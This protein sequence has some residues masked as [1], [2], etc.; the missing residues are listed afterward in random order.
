MTDPNPAPV[1]P[2]EHN[3]ALAIERRLTDQTDL[4]MQVLAQ[5]IVRA[6]NACDPLDD[7]EAENAQAGLICGLVDRYARL[8]DAL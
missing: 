1:A 4:I 5:Q 3:D 6:H 7:I 2:P 8:L